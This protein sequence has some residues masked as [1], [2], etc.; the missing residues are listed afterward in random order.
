MLFPG[1]PHSASQASWFFRDVSDWEHDLYSSHLRILLFVVTTLV[2][3]SMTVHA[4]ETS[5]PR[6][7]VEPNILVS[8]DGDVPH[9]E[10]KVVANPRNAKSL[11]AASI[12]QSSANGSWASKSYASQ[13]GG[14]SWTDSSF[15]ELHRDGG[16][17]PQVGFGSH[18]TGYFSA[19]RFFKDDKGNTRADLLFYRSEDG[20]LTWSKP[21]DLGYS[22]DH[23][24]MD[25]DHTTGKY[26]GRIYI[27]VLYGYP[28]YRVG[29]F[30]SDDD[31]R[32]FTGPVE[33]ANGGGKMG[34]NT[35]SSIV[36]L[37]DGTLII[38]YVD[39]EF[40]PEKAKKQHALNFWMVRST[41]GGVTFSAPQKIGTH[42]LDNSPEGLR[43]FSVAMAA[44][45]RSDAFP[46][47]V[48]LVWNDFQ[49]GKY[50][51]VIS[52]SSDN[53]KVWSKPVRIDTKAPAS[54]IQ[55]QPAIAVNSEGTVGVTWFDT[56]N[57][58]DQSRY[59]QYFAASVDGGNTFLPAVRI[60]LESSIPGGSGNQQLIPSA[61]V[62]Q[63]KLLM[64]FL[65]AYSRW[66]SGGDYMGLD[67][68]INGAFHS[69]WSDSRTGTF[70]INTAAVRVIKNSNAN[71]DPVAH[72]EEKELTDQV[73]IVFDR[74]KYD[75]ASKTLEVP[76][77]IKNVSSETIYGPVRLEMA[78][79]G[80][81]FDW[82]D[83]AENKKNAP[84]ILNATNGKKGEGAAFDFSPALGSEGQLNPGAISS[85]VMWRMKVVDPSTVPSLRLKVFG[86]VASK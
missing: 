8:R 82:E 42:E 64:D 27:S 83:A 57:S 13:D 60:S 10:M 85:P 78:S 72:K 63:G 15:P 77:H 74:T 1:R 33:A 35:I 49:S 16:L 62:M 31:G 3:I 2:V 18:G 71:A 52:H 6:I 9:V 56:R 70:Q 66:R 39:F 4:G 69:L 34:I 11:L 38:P 28:I 30:R 76:I 73:E 50:R 22:Y 75:A 44:A 40:D 68:D 59:D 26:A 51:M 23:P 55:Y 46:D 84:E 86:S 47:R 61:T 19:L 29:I 17:D 54:T 37:R 79:V 45:D 25:V 24:I 58:E 21:V 36:I 48:Y 53:G 43:F 80:G 14:L 7:M 65:S 20:G 67:T 12:V 41:D 81:G 32:T 5:A